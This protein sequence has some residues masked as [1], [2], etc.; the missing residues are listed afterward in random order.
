[1]AYFLGLDSTPT[2]Q[3][4]GELPLTAEQRGA[5]TAPH[6]Q[7][8]RGLSQPFPESPVHGRAPAPQ[9]RESSCAP[10]RENGGGGLSHA[11]P[12]HDYS[13]L[14]YSPLDYSPHDYSP[15]RLSPD[16]AHGIKG[17]LITAA[18]MHAP[19]PCPRLS[20]AFASCPSPA[21]R[22]PAPRCSL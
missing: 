14:D 3:H 6:A 4:S 13:P 2:T 21:G 20:R 8:G 12:P 16:P 11:A 15:R 19:S 1:M 18:R 9:L 22:Y 17:R 7:L 10:H 5:L